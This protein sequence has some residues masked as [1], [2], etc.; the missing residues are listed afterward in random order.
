MHKVTFETTSIRKSCDQLK[1]P[2]LGVVPVVASI[3]G[4]ARG[5]LGEII[6]NTPNT[7]RAPRQKFLYTCALLWLLLGSNFTAD[8]PRQ[9]LDLYSRRYLS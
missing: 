2:R 1:I 5:N 7:I 9:L 8:R 4:L 6:K 3:A